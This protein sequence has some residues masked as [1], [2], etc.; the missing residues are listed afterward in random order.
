MPSFERSTRVQ[1]PAASVWEVLADI[2]AISDWH[3]GRMY[4]RGMETLLSGP[5]ARAESLLELS[6]PTESSQ[7]QSK[8]EPGRPVPAEA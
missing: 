4:V 3:P 7:P 1:A 5:K 2:G 6:S 8:G